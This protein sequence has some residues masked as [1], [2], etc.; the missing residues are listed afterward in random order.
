[1]I[2]RP[3]DRGE[4]RTARD[5]ALAIGDHGA[6]RMHGSRLRWWHPRRWLSARELATVTVLALLAGGLWVFVVLARYVNAGEVARI[7]ERLVLALRDAADPSDPLGPLW[8]EEIMR[9]LTALGAQSSFMP[10]PL[11]GPP[12]LEAPAAPPVPG[13]PALGLPALGLGGL[14]VLV[15][16]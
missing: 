2:A 16:P 10:P 13:P 3:S 8:F 5:F 4:S 15:P 6:R 1:M 12:P 14:V 7:D 11:E 9:D